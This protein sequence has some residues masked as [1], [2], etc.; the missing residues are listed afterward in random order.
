MYM[1]QQT[2]IY[3]ENVYKSFGKEPVLSDVNL[4]IPPGKIFGVVGNNGSGK[5]EGLIT[6]YYED[7]A[8][9]AFEEVATIRTTITSPFSEETNE[10]KKDDKPAQWWIIMTMV[11]TMLTLFAAGI[12][13]RIVRRKR[14]F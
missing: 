1:E 10:T 8:G 12:A 13:I 14:K 5:T 2:G 9:N 3:V 4:S 11:G 6:F 7:E